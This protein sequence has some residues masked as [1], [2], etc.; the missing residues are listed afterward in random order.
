MTLD[1]L[2]AFLAKAK[3]DQSI[4]GKL[5]AATSPEDVVGID[6]EHGHEFSADLISLLS[7]EDLEGVSGGMCGLSRVS[8]VV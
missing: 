6:N 7:K 8:C 3:D 1:Q 2:K 4:Q 5:K